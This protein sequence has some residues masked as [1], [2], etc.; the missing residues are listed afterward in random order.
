M[1]IV[2]NPTRGKCITQA[3]FDCIYDSS[4]AGTNRQQVTL[5]T[6][7][8]C[9]LRPFRPTTK[10]PIPESVLDY[11]NVIGV[12]RAF[13]RSPDAAKRGFKEGNPAEEYQGKGAV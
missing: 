3:C 7:Y 10:S 8:A 13:Y 6:V 12:E 4:A 2:K 1:T 11:Y 9:A 5:C